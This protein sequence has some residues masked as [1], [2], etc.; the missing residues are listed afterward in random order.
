MAVKPA[1]DVRRI[2]T[3]DALMVWTPPNKPSN[4]VKSALTGV[5]HVPESLPRVGT[6]KAILVVVGSAIAAS[7][8]HFILAMVNSKFQHKEFALCDPTIS[9]T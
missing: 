3:F 6:A 4:A 9:S 1:G 7:Y 5:S 2:L 8:S